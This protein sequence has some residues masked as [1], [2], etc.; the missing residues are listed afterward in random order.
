[1]TRVTHDASSQQLCRVEELRYPQESRAELCSG[2][3]YSGASV[4]A[5]SGPGD[6]E[7]IEAQTDAIAGVGSFFAVDNLAAQ[8]NLIL[9]GHDFGQFTRF[10]SST[11]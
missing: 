4:G 11:G 3:Q 7:S 5:I 1:M 8:R 9:Q 2:V 10:P 6:S